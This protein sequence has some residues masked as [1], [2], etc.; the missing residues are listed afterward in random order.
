VALTRKQ[1]ERSPS[2]DEDRPVSRQREEELHAYFGWAPYWYDQGT[3]PR[4]VVLLHDSGATADELEMRSAGEPQTATASPKEGDPHLRSAR[5]VTGYHIHALD[6][7][8]G[9]VEDILVDDGKWTIRYLVVDTRNLLPG[10]RV[11]V[12]PAWIDSVSWPDA[13]VRLDLTREAVKQSPPYIP[14]QPLHREDEIRLYDYYG[15]PFYW[16]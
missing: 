10:K 9:H 6:G 3:M 8:I 15:R 4:D 1:I 5:E 7:D 2:I 14:T 12:A 13:R 16:K 11:L